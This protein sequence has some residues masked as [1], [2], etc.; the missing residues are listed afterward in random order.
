M[1]VKSKKAKGKI[2][3]KIAL[4]LFLPV[5]FCIYNNCTNDASNLIGFLNKGFAIT[6]RSNFFHEPQPTNG[7]S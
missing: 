5:V 7:F 6:I 4:L 2:Y 3:C 1:K